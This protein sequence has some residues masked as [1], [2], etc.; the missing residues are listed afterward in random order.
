MP[1]KPKSFKDHLQDNV[2]QFIA[3]KSDL[4]TFFS[5]VVRFG[6]RTRIWVHN[7]RESYENRHL[8][9]RRV[10][11]CYVFRLCLVI[12]FLRL[13][14]PVFVPTK[15]MLHL[16]LNPIYKFFD[17]SIFADHLL[18]RVFTLVY[19]EGPLIIFILIGILQLKELNYTNTLYN[20]IIDFSRRRHLPLNYAHT[21]KLGVVAWLLNKILLEVAFVPLVVFL[22]ICHVTVTIISYLDTDIPFGLL[23]LLISNLT[24]FAMIMQ[25][26]A[27]IF[28]ALCFFIF[29]V[30]YVRFKFNEINNSILL[31]LKF[32]HL[33]H[34]MDMKKHYGQCR[35]TNNFN[36]V[37]CLVIF[38]L[39]YMATPGLMVMIMFINVDQFILTGKII[40]TI[41]VI[42]IFGANFTL[43]LFSA[44][45]SKSARLPLNYLHRFMAENQLT[46]QEKLKTMAMIERLS[47]PDIGFY[48][49]DLFPMN[50]Y[51]F[52]L[53]V[54]NCA[55]IYFLFLSL[56]TNSF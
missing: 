22:V 35:L 43:N 12:T 15:W 32:K 46:T 42:V 48:C 6:V 23:S 20:F 36:Q 31:S 24:F 19:S 18:L 51:E 7:N 49:L 34:L 1:N 41:L 28:V 44:R 26:F 30:L 10:I 5:C 33:S 54:A 9:R 8:T 4:D 25:F 52:Y 45:V 27:Y 2:N 37:Y 29:T 14:L 38:V 17:P 55:R 39:Y 50:S 3:N 11:E 40:N 53:Y 47:G 56:I 13:I 21:R 16:V